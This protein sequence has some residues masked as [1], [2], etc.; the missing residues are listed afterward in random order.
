MHRRA[1][2]HTHIRRW[3]VCLCFWCKEAV[4][5]HKATCVHWSLQSWTPPAFT[6]AGSTQGLFTAP[7]LA[8]CWTQTAVRDS[9]CDV[10]LVTDVRSEV[11]VAWSPDLPS[12]LH[13]VTVDWTVHRRWLC[14]QPLPRFERMT[15]PAAPSPLPQVDAHTCSICAPPDT[16]APLYPARDVTQLTLDV[17]VPWPTV[18]CSS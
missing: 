1:H 16:A 4:K 5:N 13:P 17:C 6:Y 12:L 15:T 3:F 9:R 14:L 18:V 2:T 11:P 8:R 10:V 7:S